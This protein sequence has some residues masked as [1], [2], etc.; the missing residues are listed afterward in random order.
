MNAVGALMIATLLASPYLAESF[1]G[2]RVTVVLKVT[3]WDLY[4]SK[5]NFKVYVNGSSSLF[6]TELSVNASKILVF[7]VPK[8]SVIQVSGELEIVGDYGFWYRLENVNG[9]GRSVEFKADRDVLVYLNYSTNHVL[10]SPYFIAVYILIALLVVRRHLRQ[11]KTFKKAT[12][13]S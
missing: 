1:D 7:E 2:V 8:G 10:L 11:T 9:S 12:S 3:P 13:Q 6:G 5:S 4:F